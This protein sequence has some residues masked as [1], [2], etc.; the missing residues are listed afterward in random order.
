MQANVQRMFDEQSNL[1]ED[2]Q[3]RLE[4]LDWDKEEGSFLITAKLNEVPEASEIFLSYT[5]VN[6]SGIEEGMRKE[7]LMTKTNSLSFEV[8]LDL[9]INN[10]YTY[11]IISRTLGGGERLMNTYTNVLYVKDQLFENRFFESSGGI[12][13]DED[14]AEFRYQFSIDTLGYEQMELAGAEAIIRYNG[15]VIRTVDISTSVIET[16]ESNILALYQIQMADGTIPMDFS[17]EEFLVA[18]NYIIEEDN[19]IKYYV[20]NYEIPYDAF[21]ELDLNMKEA[22]HLSIALKLKFKDG[23]EWTY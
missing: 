23:F 5:A 7:V 21:P 16:T 3:Y 10:N 12:A 20:C 4:N 2:T 22:E 8:A 19:P 18:N 15:E 6:E 13:R 17:F 1:L 9:D 14:K 11:D